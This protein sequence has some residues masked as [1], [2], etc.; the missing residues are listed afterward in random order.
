[1][2]KK[3]LLII[4][5]IIVV[6]GSFVIGRQ[7]GI[8]TQNGKTQIVT[9]EETV[10]SHDIKKTLTASGTVEAKTTEKLTLDTTKYFKAMCIE[11]DDTVKVGENILEYTNGTYLTAPYDCV[12][13]SNSVPETEKKCTSG[14]Y[15][16]V[17]NLDTLVT[18]I[19]INENEVNNVAVG[20][21][22]EIKL[23]ADESKTYK[24]TITKLDSIGEYQASGSTFSATVEFEN[25]DTIKLGMSV[26]CTVILKEEKGVVAVP[27]DGVSKN[28]NGEQYVTKVNNDGS[29][30][31]I[32]VETGIAD[33]NYVQ[34]LSG[35]A[36]NDKIQIQTEITESTSNSSKNNQKGFGHGMNGESGERPEGNMPGGFKPDGEGQM[37]DMNGGQMRG[38]MQ[39]GQ[40]KEQSK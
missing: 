1:M 33:E 8:N 39:A 32:M 16:E 24:G 35:V 12:I 10:S 15:I 27:I 3:I 17:S 11:N 14:N 6:V 31:E 25:D 21:E 29:T 13:I 23:T 18:T 34:I 5:I 30:E 26:S 22:V 36:L 37:P 2:K 19:S 4:F 40:S 7:V 20:Q 38:D 28:S 9:K